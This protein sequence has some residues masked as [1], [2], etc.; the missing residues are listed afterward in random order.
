M[1]E[2]QRMIVKYINENFLK[3]SVQVELK[4]SVEVKITD[5]NGEHMVLTVNLF[6]DIMDAATKKIIAVSNVPHDLDEL[7]R[8]P[9]K[10]PTS[11]T[12][13]SQ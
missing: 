1:T 5:H 8:C 11:W 10:L 9:S 13:L 7:I 12:N 4:G 3:G 6:C 2:A